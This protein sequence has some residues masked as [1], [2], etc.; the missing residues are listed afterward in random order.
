MNDVVEFL[1]RLIAFDTVSANPNVAMVNYI[2]SFCR[3]HG[4]T[5]QRIA[6]REDGK[7]GLVAQFGPSQ[8]G[9]VV[10][11]GHCDVVPVNGQNWSRPAFK[12]TREGDRLYGRG[13][14]DMKGFLACMMAAGKAAAGKT[15][16]RPLTLVFSYDEEIGCVGIQE[17]KHQLGDL[18]TAPRLCIVGEPTGMQIATSHKGKVAMHATC[19]GQSG[20]S[21]LAPK[22]V[23]ALHMAAD[24][25]SKLRALQ[26]W[27]A[28]HG[29]QDP[30][31]DIP[32]T[33]LHIGQL[34][35]GAAL[36][37]VPDRAGLLLEYRYLPSDGADVIFDKLCQIANEVSHSYQ[38]AFAEAAI[39]LD[40]YNSYPGFEVQRSSDAVE[41]A[42]KL[43]PNAPFTKV[44][45]GTEAGVFSEM[46]IPSVVCGPGSMSGQG[47]K[48]DEYIT[49]AQLAACRSMLGNVVET[50]T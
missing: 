25:V 36:N 22:F 34:H 39:S 12:L 20:H 26:D 23:N 14:T 29:A 8:A 41:F 4:A 3:A 47:H 24:F 35:G 2:E 40:R 48:P 17:M 5:T 15:L 30:D 10:L 44:A 38:D 16:T 7:V 33:T 1:D 43:M 46:G 6:G 9:G 18:L 19:H 11:S 50:L 13:T 27:Y 31:Y 37:V 45:F 49:I 32:Y 21:A 42:R 28:T